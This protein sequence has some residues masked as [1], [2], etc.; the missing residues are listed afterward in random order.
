MGDASSSG[1]AA[2]GRKR[3]AGEFDNSQQQLAAGAAGA[4]G[5]GVA[6]CAADAAVAVDGL[7]RNASKRVASAS[8]GCSRTPGSTPGIES[9][10]M[11]SDSETEAEHEDAAP[12]CAVD[13]DAA[14]AAA[15]AG[16]VLRR[17]GTRAQA[18]KGV[19]PRGAANR[20]GPRWPQRAPNC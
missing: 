6:S 15:A 14:A 16:R 1:A 10:G 7:H 5:V 4:A 13:V 20:G 11:Q 2:G 3:P 19:G 12:H 9:D 17:A 18:R 8:R